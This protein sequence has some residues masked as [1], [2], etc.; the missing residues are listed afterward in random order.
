MQSAMIALL[1]LSLSLAGGCAASVSTRPT[2]PTQTTRQV[3]GRVAGYTTAGRG[4]MDGV[5][6][7]DGTRVHFPP[8]LGAMVLPLLDRGQPVRIVGTVENRAAGKIL[9]ATAITS[10]NSGKTVYVAAVPPPTP[11]KV[12]APDRSKSAQPAEPTTLTG[13]DLRASEGRVKGYS[14]APGG[15]MDGVVLDNGTRIH[16]PPHAGEAVLPLV[17]QGQ[18]IR[19]IGWN[20]AGPEGA[21]IEATKIIATPSGTTVDISSLPP[22]PRARTIT[23]GEVA[24]PGQPP[25]TA[26]EPTRVR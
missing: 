18:T 15:A 26:P 8:R 11:E 9:E 12:S 20:L 5:I 1:C 21:V 10:V 7:E 13:A 23:P 19:V 14:A 25:L 24:V 2:A 6:L 22:P 17:K 4:E 3:T 16:F